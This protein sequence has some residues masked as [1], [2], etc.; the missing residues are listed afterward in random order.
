MDFGGLTRR[1]EHL[2][3]NVILPIAYMAD[4]TKQMTVKITNYSANVICF[5]NMYFSFKNESISI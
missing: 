5:Q 2:E 1:L 3:A 4:M